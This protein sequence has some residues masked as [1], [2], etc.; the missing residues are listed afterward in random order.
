MVISI[1]SKEIAPAEA[2]IKEPANCIAT[3]PSTSRGM[4]L[5][6]GVKSLL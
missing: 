3:R 6:R 5:G 4:Q 2:P 1:Q